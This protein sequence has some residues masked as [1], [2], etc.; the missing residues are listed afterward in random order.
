MPPDPLSPHLAWGFGPGPFHSTGRVFWGLTKGV[1][2]KNAN[3]TIWEGGPK[4]SV[5]FAPRYR[6]LEI[7]GGIVGRRPGK[8]KKKVSA[9]PT[10]SGLSATRLTSTTVIEMTANDEILEALMSER[11][12]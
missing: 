7:V 2:G 6:R 5:I 8:A 3:T 10:F 9:I 11:K 12:A 4:G 1:Y